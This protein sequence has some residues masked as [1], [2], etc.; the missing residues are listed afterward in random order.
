MRNRI[1]IPILY[2]IGISFLMPFSI[3]NILENQGS[4][5]ILLPYIMFILYQ[6]F[7][8]HYDSKMDKR[9]YIKCNLISIITIFI[10]TILFNAFDYPI[11]DI[12]KNILVSVTIA[13]FIASF[14]SWRVTEYIV[15]QA[16][17]RASDS[18]RKNAYYQATTVA[19]CITLLIIPVLLIFTEYFHMI[20][21]ILIVLIGVIACFIWFA[22]GINN[23]SLLKNHCAIIK[24]IIGFLLLLIIVAD[25]Y[26]KI[27]MPQGLLTF[28]E[29]FQF[30]SLFVVIGIFFYLLNALLN[31]YTDYQKQIIEN[32]DK[33]ADKT[34]GYKFKCI[35]KTMISEP[36]N[37]NRLLGIGSFIPFLLIFM[38]DVIKLKGSTEYADIIL[39][40]RATEIIYI[41][42]SCLCIVFDVVQKIFHFRKDYIILP[43]EISD[44]DT[45]EKSISKICTK[46]IYGFIKLSRLFTSF[47]IEL[48]ILI[49][50][51]IKTGDFLVSVIYGIPFMLSAMTG[52]AINDVFDYRKD[53]INK[54]RR[55]LPSN[56]LTVKQ[57]K[58]ISF[59]LG[60]LSFI[61]SLC[62]A[63]TTIQLI[64][65]LS[66]LLGVLIYNSVV[67]YIAIA[68]T[69]CAA[70][71]CVLPII[72][73][74][75]TIDGFELSIYISMCAYMYILGREIRMDI[76][77]FEGDIID[78]IKT[79][80]II[81]GKNKAAVI[82]YIVILLSV[83]LSCMFILSYSKTLYTLLFC[84]LIISSQLLC[85]LLWKNNEK[86]L[87]KQSILLQ[88]IPMLLTFFV[89]I[90][91]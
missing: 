5:N 61:S 42:I 30:S 68:K 31:E 35:L 50:C 14:E 41:G 7:V 3:K 77:D 64:L 20:F 9:A 37:F 81:L 88:W 89:S 10:I 91:I 15:N 29:F 66:A 60:T 8:F 65:Y 87:K 12:F 75:V 27:P 80:P 83:I 46:K 70:L 34:N 45:K 40:M 4:I 62:I 79:L 53:K 59:V 67:K 52:F 56:L 86:N 33:F 63:E 57:A 54:P 82:A 44:I 11:A 73:T 69:L 58:I 85:E 25:A 24:T 6:Y 26:T 49:P 51:Y 2:S 36:R 90:A 39:R 17:N 32:S 71:I 18:L 76:L 48:I 72:F 84:T 78:N 47:A 38:V 74:S 28:N 21:Y 43:T 13:A 22:H 19:L 55:A 1:T 23:M 16:P